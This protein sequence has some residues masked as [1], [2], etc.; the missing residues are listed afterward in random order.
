M[1]EVKSTP[2][3]TSKGSIHR[4]MK[5]EEILNGFPHR[6]QLLAQAMLNAGLQC[7]GC[8]AAVWETL[9]DG[10]LSH[11]KSEE[12][13]DQMVDLLNEI[14]EE[15]IVADSITLTPR[16]AKKYLI[17]LEE[18]DKNGWGLRIGERR[19]GCSGFE[20]TLDYSETPLPTDAV[21]VSQGIEIHVDKGSL[22]SLLGVEVDYIDG[23]NGS[24]F[25]ISNP[26]VRKACHCGNS[27]GY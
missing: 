16:A 2:N 12:E 10:M 26:N 20:Y 23:L 25:K 8:G 24:G 11:G 14:L 6:A 1:S 17:I 4:K 18:E 22:N 5:I 3:A 9:E 13:V 7:V 21:F 27:H 15:E 19:A